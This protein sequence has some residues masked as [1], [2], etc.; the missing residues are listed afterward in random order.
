MSHRGKKV[1]HQF[2][3]CARTAKWEDWRQTPLAAS[4]REEGW[5]EAV[6]VEVVEVVVGVL[7][8][9]CAEVDGRRS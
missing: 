5:D 7:E 2:G 8:I 3:A 4:A 9:G 6:V 1:R